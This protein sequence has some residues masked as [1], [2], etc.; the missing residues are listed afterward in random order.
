MGVINNNKTLAEL[1]SFMNVYPQRLEGI[2]VQEKVP[3]E[4]VP[5]LRDTI[6]DCEKALDGFGRT[7]V[8]YSGTENKIRILVEAEKQK[9]VDF[10][11]NKLCDTAKKELT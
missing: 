7:V 10:W 6:K 2:M 3:I 9:D 1:A 4:Q 8:R 11:T 5:A